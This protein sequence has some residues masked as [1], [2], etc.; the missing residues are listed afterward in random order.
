M[1]AVAAEEPVKLRDAPADTHM[2]ATGRPVRL[3]GLATSVS[4]GACLDDRF[5]GVCWRVVSRW[6]P[7]EV[8]VAV[9]S[10][11]ANQCLVRVAESGVEGAG[12]GVVEVG[13]D[14]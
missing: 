5:Q 9:W 8:V 13:E 4:H 10:R 1:G 7:H 12:I 2:R 3:P 14:V 11:A 6:R